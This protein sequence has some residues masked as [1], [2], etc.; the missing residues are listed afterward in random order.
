MVELQQRSDLCPLPL[1]GE[2]DL[3]QLSITSGLD[4]T[5]ST[6]SSFLVKSNFKIMSGSQDAE[7]MTSCRVLAISPREIERSRTSEM[8]TR[9]GNGLGGTSLGARSGYH[10]FGQMRRTQSG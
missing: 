7:S 9:W 4:R 3:H 1:T 2:F 6:T 10:V 8:C 5:L